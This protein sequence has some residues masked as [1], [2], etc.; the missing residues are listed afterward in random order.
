MSLIDLDAH[1]QLQDVARAAGV[2]KSTVAAA[3][4]QGGGGKNARVSPAR[5][6]EIRRIAL[7]MGY[8]PDP[9]AGGLRGGRTRSVA[10]VWHYVDPWCLDGVVGS[11]IL[12]TLQQEGLATYQVEHPETPQ[13]LLAALRELLL[14]RVDALV[15][16]PAQWMIER[17]PRIAEALTSFHSVLAVLPWK[18]ED[19]DVDQVVHDRDPGIREVVAHFAATGRRRPAV[20]MNPGDNT[21]QHKLGVFREACAQAGIRPHRHDVIALQG[22][23]RPHP[24]RVKEYQE[25]MGR[26]FHGCKDVDAILCVNDV[27]EMA[28][29]KYLREQGIVIGRDV[30]LVGLND[31]IALSLWDPPLASI[32]RNHEDLIREILDMLRRRRENPKLPPQ[33]RVVPMHFVWRES[34]GPRKQP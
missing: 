32:D 9:F 18:M 31:P 33:T 27:G 25:A 23:P 8:R 5:A 2:A 1:V 3:L 12:S 11:T 6:S 14:R 20:V 13:G 26:D 30:A 15:L 4:R 17:E 7:E 29:A 28:V 16:R 24:E 22:Y 19:W 21:D 10:C 34:A